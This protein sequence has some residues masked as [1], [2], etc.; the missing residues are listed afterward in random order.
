MASG[1]EHKTAFRCRY[2]LFEYNVMPFDLCNASDSF[3]EFMNEILHDFVDDFVIVY[4][5]D[6]LIY[7][8]NKREHRRHVRLVLERLRVARIHFKPFKCVFDA[9]EINFLDYIINE[10]GVSMDPSKVSSRSE[11]RRVGK[12]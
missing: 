11:E 3:Q 8:K 9:E 12:E 1:E 2:G 7:F 5:N 10:K 4:L 6:I